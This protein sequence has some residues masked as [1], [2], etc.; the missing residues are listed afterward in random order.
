MRKENNV[1][2]LQNYFKKD[3]FSSLESNIEK[4]ERLIS[5]LEKES[6]RLLKEA[7][8]LQAE[9]GDIV[10]KFGLFKI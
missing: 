3:N 1:I 6:I 5:S 9:V 10:N 7:E 8:K 2:Y 4:I